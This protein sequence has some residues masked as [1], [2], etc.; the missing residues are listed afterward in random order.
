MI[1]KINQFVNPVRNLRFS[2]LKKLLSKFSNGVKV[3]QEEIILV[4]GVILISLLS[5]AAGYITAR[6]QEKQPIR[7]EEPSINIPREDVGDIFIPLL[8][9]NPI[10]PWIED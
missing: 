10:P 9:K 6:L 3:H 4:I 2:H 1:E 8:T 5:F 7:F